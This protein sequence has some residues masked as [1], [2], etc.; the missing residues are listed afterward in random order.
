M[1]VETSKMKL[2]REK[3]LGKKARVSENCGDKHTRYDNALGR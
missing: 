3:R 2:Q 1:S